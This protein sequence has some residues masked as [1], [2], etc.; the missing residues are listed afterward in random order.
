MK[1]H[2]LSKDKGLALNSD[3]SWLSQDERYQRQTIP[4]AAEGSKSSCQPKPEEKNL[5]QFQM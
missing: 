1:L 2:V 5:S 3:R 4:V